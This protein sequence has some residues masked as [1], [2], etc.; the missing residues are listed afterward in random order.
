MRDMQSAPTPTD[1]EI[2]AALAAVH[3]YLEQ[4]AL[5][6]AALSGAPAPSARSWNT[7]AVLAAQG[8]PPTLGGTHRGW[9][10]AERAARA[11]RWS[12]GIIGM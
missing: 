9:G 4:C 7:A 3:R 6:E 10:V 12:Y 8:L 5:D 2:A 1:D 11:S